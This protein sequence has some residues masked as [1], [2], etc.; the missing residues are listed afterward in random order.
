M[1]R[2]IFFDQFVL[3]GI[4]ELILSVGIVVHFSTYNVLPWGS[5]SMFVYYSVHCLPD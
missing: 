2:Q 1:Q 5:S 3:S 4:N